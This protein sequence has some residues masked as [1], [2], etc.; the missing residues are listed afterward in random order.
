MESWEKDLPR[1]LTSEIRK[2]LAKLGRRSS[3]PNL[4]QPRLP[5]LEDIGAKRAIRIFS[6]LE[7]KRTAAYHVPF[8]EIQEISEREWDTLAYPKKTET[9]SAS[10]LKSSFTHVYPPGQMDRAQA[11]SGERTAIR[12]LGGELILTPAG[13][14][15]K[16][17][18]AIL[19][20]KVEMI[21]GGRL[22]FSYEGEFQAVLT[23]GEKGSSVQSMV[24]V[25]EA[26][27][28]Q[29]RNGRRGQRSRVSGDIPFAA[30]FETLSLEK[31]KKEGDAPK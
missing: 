28:P 4:R 6:G 30:V 20:G 29:G 1:H 14:K 31:K 5:N 22:R 21:Y 8:V 23:Y 10:I 9:V 12:T 17:R 19:R 3:P 2:A 24:G 16:V 11:G 15:G 13:S 18:F 7:K 27:Y 25:F 26:D